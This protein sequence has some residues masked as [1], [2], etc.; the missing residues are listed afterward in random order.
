MQSSFFLSIFL[1]FSFSIS[2]SLKWE[3]ASIEI[4]SKYYFPYELC[5]LNHSHSHSLSSSLNETMGIFQQQ[6]CLEKDQDSGYQNISHRCRLG[7]IQ[8]HMNTGTC[9]SEKWGCTTLKKRSGL[10]SYLLNLIS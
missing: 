7:A 2:L 6:D 9:I 1:S 10:I 4:I 5:V 8:Q 3:E